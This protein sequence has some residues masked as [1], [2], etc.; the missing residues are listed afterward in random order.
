MLLK[1]TILVFELLDGEDLVGSLYDV[2]FYFLDSDSL[3][4]IYSLH[5]L[6]VIYCILG[7]LLHR[8]RLFASFFAF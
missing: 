8:D 6:C 1:W 3:V 7:C 4:L 2:L 5:V